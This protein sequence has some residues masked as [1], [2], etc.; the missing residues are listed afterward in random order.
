MSY[1]QD[2]SKHAFA[3]FEVGVP[4]TDHLFLQIGFSMRMKMQAYRSRNPKNQT[5]TGLRV[6]VGKGH[7]L[8]SVRLVAVESDWWHGMRFMFG[9]G[10]QM[11]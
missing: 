6:Y 1:V 9:T 8:T 11:F 4:A 5:I 2:M 3:P 10:P 7:A